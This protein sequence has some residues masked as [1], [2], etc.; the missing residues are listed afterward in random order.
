M[1]GDTVVPASATRTGWKTSLG[2]AARVSTTP[3]R[4]CSMCSRSNGS[5][6]SSAARAAA[7][8]SRPPSESHFSRAAGSSAGPSKMK[9]A[10]G[11]KSARVWIFSS[12]IATASRSPEP[13]GWDR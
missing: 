7:S 2:L 8:A 13:G 1:P 3:R 6:A 4:D 12:E 5:V 11:Q 9:P 10:S